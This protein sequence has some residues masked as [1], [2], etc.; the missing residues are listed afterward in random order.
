MATA[1]LVLRRSTN[2]EGLYPIVVLISHKGTNTEIATKVA[3]EKKYWDNGRIKRGCPQ[4]DNVR[5]A[6]TKLSIKL[7]D[8][9]Y[10]LDVLEEKRRLDSMTAKQISDFVK[11]GGKAHSDRSFVDYFEEYIPQI[12]NEGTREKY[13]YTLKV[14]KKYS[15]TL[16]LSEINKPWLYRFKEWRMQQ[17][18]PAT[19]NMDLRNI[20][21]LINRAIDVD[22][23]VGQEVYP[24][25]KFEFC[26]LEP[27]NL[28]LPVETI[29]AIR[30]IDLPRETDRNARDFFMLSFYFIGI[31]NVDLFNLEPMEGGRVEY[32]RK[33]TS[34]RYS[35]KVE[36]E[37]LEII[38][39]HRGKRSFLDF[40]ERY[41]RPNTVNKMINYYLKR[42]GGLEEINV[43]DL[44]MYHARHSWAGIAARKPIGASKPLIAQALGHGRLTVTD[45]YFDYDTELVDDLNRRV[46][47]LLKNDSLNLE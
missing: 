39:R 45:T 44:V 17:V 40:T 14:L 27:R 34:K 18:T 42:I 11:K 6:N 47:D 3:I 19:V 5:E 30:D 25:R 33:K 38:N 43:P 1:R 29:Q 20:R 24:F 4:V 7:N 23:I 41:S 21:A 13:V 15:P 36:P 12:D 26:K 10:F 8:V 28:R 35:I 46:L 9:H 22:E 32:V 31:N 37:A 16:F 2:K